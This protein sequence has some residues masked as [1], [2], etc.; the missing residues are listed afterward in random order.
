[1]LR[2]KAIE[3]AVS[4][5]TQS[6]VLK[7]GGFR[8]INAAHLKRLF[9]GDSVAIPEVAAITES[10]KVVIDTVKQR[11]GTGSGNKKQSAP[12]PLSA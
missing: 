4:K 9:P 10:F 5:V 6:P 12:A 3:A 1:M 8:D 2:L 7:A 11:P